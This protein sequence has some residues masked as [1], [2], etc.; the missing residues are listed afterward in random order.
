MTMD[1]FFLSVD[2]LLE[3][4]PW[5]SI[6]P[7]LKRRARTFCTY[8]FVAEFRWRVNSPASWVDVEDRLI[9]LGGLAS[10]SLELASS[11]ISPPFR[12]LSALLN[13]TGQV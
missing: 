13:A 9:L 8:R 3:D 1:F 6:D 12:F 4:Q 7:S 2:S 10:S 11:S 5:M